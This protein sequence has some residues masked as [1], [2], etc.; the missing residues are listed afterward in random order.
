[1]VIKDVKPGVKVIVAI[2]G[3]GK[4]DWPSGVIKT[5]PYRIGEGDWVCTL[6]NSEIVEIQN[7]IEF[8]I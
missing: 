4:D 1:M 8:D 3:I 5:V 6:E 7:L 2:Q